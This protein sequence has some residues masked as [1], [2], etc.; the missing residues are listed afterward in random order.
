MEIII[1]FDE[2]A[3]PLGL[4]KSWPHNPVD[5]SGP[6]IGAL[7]GMLVA[8]GKIEPNPEEPYGD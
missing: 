3:I 6:M 5:P 8:N 4:R 2:H 1:R 7:Y